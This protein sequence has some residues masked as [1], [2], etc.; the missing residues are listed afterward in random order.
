MRSG[1]KNERAWRFG[2][3]AMMYECKMLLLLDPIHDT[4]KSSPAAA[5]PSLQGNRQAGFS[6]PLN[7]LLFMTSTIIAFFFTSK[8][9]DDFR[10]SSTI[11]KSVLK[12]A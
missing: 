11:T 3:G 12:K 4:I 9:H 5:S 6:N 2:P 7:A 1:K 10:S 8:T